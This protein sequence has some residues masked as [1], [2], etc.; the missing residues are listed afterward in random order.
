MDPDI[1]RLTSRPE[2]GVM[3]YMAPECFLGKISVSS[4]IYSFGCTLLELF[5][6]Q[7]PWGTPDAV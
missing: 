1:S 4:D 5:T 2:A 7:I 3:N 6:S